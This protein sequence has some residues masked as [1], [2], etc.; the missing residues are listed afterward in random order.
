[1]YIKYLTIFKFPLENRLAISSLKTLFAINS[2]AAYIAIPV[3]G[4]KELAAV[5][6]E[7]A[8]GSPSSNRKGGLFGIATATDAKQKRNEMIVS[9]P[10][11]E[12]R[13]S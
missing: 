7:I 1:M 2:F 12:A 4:D 11:V 3:T 5:Y 8:Y 9:S 13:F 6:D 10:I